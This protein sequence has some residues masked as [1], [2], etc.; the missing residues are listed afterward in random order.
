M[1]IKHGFIFSPGK[2]LG[3]GKIQLNMVDEDLAFY[4][5]WKVEEEENG[6]I[7]CT[8]E[9]QVKG[10]SDIMMNHFIFSDITPDSFSVVMENYAVGKVAGKGFINDNKI[11][12]EFRVEEIGFEGFEFYEKQEDD[13]YHV[14]GEFST[15]EDLRTAVLGKVWRKVNS[16]TE[17]TDE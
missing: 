1:V 5:R 17:K 6:I 3:E 15:Q 13:L 9:I 8:Q 12:W 16:S 11:G 10:L 7:E 2:W 4:T 14:H